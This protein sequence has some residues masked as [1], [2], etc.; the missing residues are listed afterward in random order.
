MLIV[1]SNVAV[2][3]TNCTIVPSLCLIPV[4][5]TSSLPVPLIVIVKISPP[6]SIVA[7][8]I[9]ASFAGVAPPST[10]PAITN[11]SPAKYPEPALLI[12]E[13]YTAPVLV[14]LKSALA[15]VPEGYVYAGLG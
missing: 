9:V 5:T 12:F 3:P 11:V 14:I 7:T 13:V 10:L 6:T 8:V 15:P 4:N 2:E 1:T